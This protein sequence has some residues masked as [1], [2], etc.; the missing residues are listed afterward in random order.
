MKSIFFILILTSSLTWFNVSCVDT[1]KDCYN[2]YLNHENFNYTDHEICSRLFNESL[3]KFR[4][5]VELAVMK[6]EFVKDSDK[7]FVRK[8]FQS[9][10][11]IKIFL[12][13]LA[14]NELQSDPLL[15]KSFDDLV[16]PSIEELTTLPNLLCSKES[17]YNMNRRIALEQ[18]MLYETSMVHREMNEDQKC[19]LKNFLDAVVTKEN[20][21]ILNY[22][23]NKAAVDCNQK[24]AVEEEEESELN[25]IYAFDMSLQQIDECKERGTLYSNAHDNNSVSEAVLLIFQ[26]F[27][28]SEVQEEELKKILFNSVETSAHEWLKCMSEI[29]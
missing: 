7:E 9:D 25:D 8:W 6:D 14:K 27:D 1:D 15:K 19:L 23:V 10:K 20:S 26:Y 12:R 4:Q 21:H 3:T 5:K 22:Q 2:N 13:S 11:M 24:F 28:V 18:K 16:T 17:H 29:K